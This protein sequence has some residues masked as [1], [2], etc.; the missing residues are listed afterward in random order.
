MISK[1]NVFMVNFNTTELTNFAIKS[2][3]QNAGLENYTINV[4]DNSNRISFTTR[5]KQI[6]ILDNTKGQLIDVNKMVLDNLKGLPY[7]KG[8]YGSYMHC[9][10]IQYILDNFDN[11]L[12]FDSDIVVKKKIDFID[13]N[14]IGCFHIEKPRIDSWGFHVA[15]RAVPF[16]QYFNTKLIKELGIRYLDNDRICCGNVPM[17]TK[18]VYDT[19]AS[20]LEDV[21]KFSNYKTFDFNDY[22]NHLRA[23]SWQGNRNI[24]RFMQQNSRYVK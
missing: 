12:L 1:L 21:K 13:E 14:A 20:F 23:A 16:I 4:I 3:I 22:I 15:E 24:T 17:K 9:A 10:T 7:K 11:V 6:N 2:I 5:N 18:E 19:G 8:K